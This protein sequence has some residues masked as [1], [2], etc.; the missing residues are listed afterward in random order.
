MS[1][2]EMAHGAGGRATAELVRALFHRHFNNEWLAQ[3]NDQATFEVTAGRM[4]MSTDAHVV[5]PLFFPGG[6]I[7]SL[8]GAWHHQR[9]RHGRR[10]A[11]LSLRRLHPR[12]R[13]SARRSRAHRRVAWRRPRATAGVPIVTGDTKVVERG[14]ADGVF[15]T[16]TGIGVVPEGVASLGDRRGPATRS[17]SRPHRR[18]R[19]GDHVAAREPELRH[20]DPSRTRAALHGL[21]AAMMAAGARHPR[22]ARSDPR[23]PGHDLERDRPAVAASA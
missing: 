8:V 9:C 4:V 13:L 20:R 5:S 23:R 17:W 14:K 3:A 15:I 21:V 16:T 22:A 6:D 10:A 2:V 19:H 12:R 7:G 18:P 11:A 1:A